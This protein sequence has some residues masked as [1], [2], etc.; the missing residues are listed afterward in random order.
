[1]NDFAGYLNAIKTIASTH[2]VDMASVAGAPAGVSS[3]LWAVGLDGTPSKG[4]QWRLSSYYVPDILTST[5]ADGHWTTALS[6]NYELR[7]GAQAMYQSSN[8]NDALTGS[9]FSTGTVGVR[10]DLSAGGATATFAYN[11]T[12][13]GAAYRT[14]YGGWAGYTF[15]IVKSFNQA[16]EKA[17]LIGGSYDFAK[18][19]LPGLA[20]NASIVFGRDSIDASTGAPLQNNTEYDLTLDYRF[21][22]ER[23]PAWARP[24]WIRARAAYVDQGTAGDVNDYRIIVNYPWVL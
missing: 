21:T 19:D 22:A 24:L 1:V 6:A 18:H 3:P 5:F 23:W 20:L 15:M 12:G 10:A 17:Y 4:S 16:G 11:Q 7:L 14:P 2:F 9:R 8:G 13:T